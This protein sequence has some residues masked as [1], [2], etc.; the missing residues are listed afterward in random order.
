M[1]KKIN[2]FFFFIQI[3]CQA[4]QQ[5]LFIKTIEQKYNNCTCQV[6]TQVCTNNTLLQIYINQNMC[7]LFDSIPKEIK[8]LS[9]VVYPI[10]DNYNDERFNYNKRFN[11]FPHAIIK[12]DNTEQISYVLKILKKY[13][14]NFSLRSGGHCF[15]PGSLSPDYII[16]LTNFNKIIPNIEKKEV[17]I[18]A[19]CRLGCIIEKLGKID[20]AIP[21]GDSG[22]NGVTGLALGGGVGLLTRK[23]GLTCD[24]IKNIIFINANLEVI[25]VN[26]DNYPDLLW[27]LCG[28]GGG[29]FGIVV[30][31]TFKMYFVPKVSVLILNFNWNPT[32]ISEIIKA[33][34]NWIK[35][36]P[37]D[38][39]SYLDIGY[40]NNKIS[41]K[42]ISVKVGNEPFTE[43]QNT[44]KKFNPK[45]GLHT[46]RYIDAAK[47]FAGTSTFP[48]LKAKSKMLFDPLSNEGIQVIIDYM[49]KLKLDMKSFSIKFQI[50]SG[51]GKVLQGNTS[52]FPRNALAWFFQFAYW[53]LQ[54]QEVE[55]LSS[56]NN[57]Y[58]NISPFCSQFSYSNLVD[59]DLGKD[60]LNA[61]YGDHVDRLIKIK[62]KYDPSNIFN[63]RQ[64]IPLSK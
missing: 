45:V 35:T 43:W 61:Y 59:Y 7:K 21:T 28:A 31:F 39:T 17:F 62:N 11:I 52:Y 6:P 8:N 60:Y 33:W 49:Q 57:F 2:L 58:H 4:N 3:V 29:S 25:N 50:Y 19:G 18:G 26:K 32:K 13:K 1:I 22:S 44:F 12:P 27:A 41:F 20:F 34:Q 40:L 63:W 53:N 46:E 15:G 36:L 14:L 10:S 47:I 64:S 48:F 54:Q 51:R 55:A 9:Y 16:D 5:D 30:G 42:I 37:N 23:F 56:I 38:I 24:S